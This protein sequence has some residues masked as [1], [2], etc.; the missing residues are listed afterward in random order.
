[1]T[2]ITPFY[3]FQLLVINARRKRNIVR[4]IEL[5][6]KIQIITDVTYHLE[7]IQGL[8]QTFRYSVKKLLRWKMPR[9]NGQLDF[10]WCGK[11]IFQVRLHGKFRCHDGTYLAE[12]DKVC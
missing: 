7:T 2:C 10:T 5:D 8:K 1:D 4:V 3:D 6:R 12:C 9:M 11:V